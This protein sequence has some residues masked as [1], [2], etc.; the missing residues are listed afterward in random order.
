M[1]GIEE[2]EPPGASLRL[3]RRLAARGQPPRPADRSEDEDAAP[4]ERGEG[5]DLSP[6]VRCVAADVVELLDVDD[7]PG[8]STGVKLQ[9]RRANPST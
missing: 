8:E 7:D 1:T 6:S 2:S 5:A 4:S 3:G 9:E